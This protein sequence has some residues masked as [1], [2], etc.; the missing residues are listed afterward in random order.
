MIISVVSA[1]VGL[2]FP[3]FLKNILGIVISQLITGVSY[4]L[5]VLA[6]QRHAGLA[7]DSKD[8]GIAQFS[9][10]MGIGSFLGPLF[11]GFLSDYFN[12]Y[13]AFGIL[14]GV[15]FFPILFIY[16]LKSYSSSMPDK[17]NTHDISVFTLLKNKILQEAILVSIII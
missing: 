12:Y 2:L 15:S 1:N 16:Y 9:L 14:S 3:F 11:S 10:G 6:A 4:T 13:I 17:T 8:G 7:F 5:F